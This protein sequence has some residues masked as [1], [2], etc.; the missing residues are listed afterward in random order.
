MCG[1]ACLKIVL[2]FFGVR[3]SERVI[4]TACNAT[5]ASGTTGRNL[6]IGAERLGLR[7]RIIDRASFPLIGKWLRRGVPVIVDW[8]STVTSDP[9]RE[10]M[11]CGHYSVVYGLNRRDIFLQDPAVGQR[12]ISRDRFLAVWFDFEDVFPQHTR[13]LLIRRLIVAAPANFF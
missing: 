10:S 12:R 3:K 1:P 2:A 6:A 5:P 8:M 13:D 11:A 9:T 7:A 4:A